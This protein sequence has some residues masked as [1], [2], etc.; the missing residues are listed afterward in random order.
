MHFLPIQEI[1]FYIVPHTQGKSPNSAT[2]HMVQCSYRYVWLH[3]ISPH[4]QYNSQLPIKQK[5]NRKTIP[6]EDLRYSPSYTRVTLF[7][8]FL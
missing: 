8:K 7:L 2:M 6:G 5:N 3:Y 1:F 4:I